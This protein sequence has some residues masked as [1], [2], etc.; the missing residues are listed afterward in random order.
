MEIRLKNTVTKK[1]KNNGVI[2]MLSFRAV[3]PTADAAFSAVARDVQEVKAE[4][5]RMDIASESIELTAVHVAANMVETE[6]HVGERIQRGYT[7]NG[8]YAAGCVSVT[9]P[10]SWADGIHRF[11]DIYS[12]FENKKTHQGFQYNFTCLNKEEYAAELRSELVK[13]AYK[14]VNQILAAGEAVD[15]PVLTQVYYNCDEP[16]SR[17]SD[18]ACASVYAQSPVMNHEQP[19]SAQLIDLMVTPDTATF[20]ELRDSITSVWSVNMV[21]RNVSY[22]S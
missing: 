16:S 15:P 3:E 4:M 10:L 19:V 7:Q 9:L 11:G 8:Y 5:Q 2:F 6:E 13:D 22:E 17:T 20:V 18:F 14:Q 21:R 12:L 1:V